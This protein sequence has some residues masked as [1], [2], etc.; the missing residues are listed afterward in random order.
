MSQA[1]DD[2]LPKEMG[3]SD[4]K[5]SSSSYQNDK[6]LSKQNNAGKVEEVNV[7]V[8]YDRKQYLEKERD[9][10]DLDD[11]DMELLRDYNRMKAFQSLGLE[12]KSKHICSRLKSKIKDMQNKGISISYHMLQVAYD[13]YENKYHSQNY[14]NAKLFFDDML[15][16]HD[17]HVIYSTAD[18]TILD[19]HLKGV[20]DLIEST[21]ILVPIDVAFLHLKKQYYKSSD[22]AQQSK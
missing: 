11:I 1:F 2:S 14:P 9:K 17:Q 10:P 7:E 3:A 6:F 18:K 12:E 16:V 4:N 15:P 22:D 13:R 5:D 19:Q 20:F 21:V 8:L